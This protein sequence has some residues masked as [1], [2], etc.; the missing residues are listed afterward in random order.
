[1]FTTL[2]H[3]IRSQ[4]KTLEAVDRLNILDDKFAFLMSGVQGTII[5][6][7]QYLKLY[8]QMNFKLI[9]STR[10]IYAGAYTHR[11]FLRR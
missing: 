4:N 6:V 8:R 11:S 5:E 7:M 9:S 1:M 2:V 10:R 3:A